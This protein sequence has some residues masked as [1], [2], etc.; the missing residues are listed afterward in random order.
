MFEMEQQVEATARLAMQTS[1]DFAEHRAALQGMFFLAG[2]AKQKC[3]EV[4]E[5]YSRDRDVVLA[6]IS[7]L[8]NSSRTRHSHTQRADRQWRLS[9]MQTLGGHLKANRGLWW[10]VSRPRSH[11][12]TFE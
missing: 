10:L 6:C 1:I 7:V 12:P 2:A 3:L 5:A 8:Y 11:P 4:Y 9:A